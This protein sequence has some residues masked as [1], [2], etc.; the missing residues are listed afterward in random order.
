MR[1][2][3]PKQATVPPD[4]AI[5]KPVRATNS[6]ERFKRLTFDD[7]LLVLVFSGADVAVAPVD[8]HALAAVQLQQLLA[9]H[10][11]GL[12]VVERQTLLQAQK[13]DVVGGVDGAGHAVDGVRHRDA[14]SQNGVVLDVVDSVQQCNNH[15]TTSFGSISF[16]KKKSQRHLQNS[17]K[18]Y[19]E[20]KL[21]KVC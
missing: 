5:E 13:V 18:S 21:A 14:P 7:H 2:L 16:F 15:S 9:K 6:M 4:V 12:G 19:Q 17:G 10:L 3:Q 8:L 1:S 20:Q 11:G